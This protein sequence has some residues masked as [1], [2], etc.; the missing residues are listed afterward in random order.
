LLTYL[1]IVG[2]GNK[3]DNVGAD[4]IPMESPRAVIDNMPPCGFAERVGVELNRAER[5][6]VF[7]SLT[8]LDLGGATQAAG[9]N[10]TETLNSLTEAVKESVRAC[11][12]VELLGDHCLALLLPETPRQ[13]AE[14]ASRRLAQMVRERL[15][16]MTDNR[17]DVVIPVEIASYPDTAGARPLTSFL[18][19]LAKR[20]QN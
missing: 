10:I 20:S 19:D 14:I 12:Y 3:Q 7:V 2:S 13:G 5:Y 4:W 18:E 11:D 17:V 16:D 8:V 6:R 9:E 15:R 1:R